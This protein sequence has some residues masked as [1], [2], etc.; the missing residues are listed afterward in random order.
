MAE[1]PEKQRP[2]KQRLAQDRE[3]LLAEATALVERIE[4]DVDEMD[5]SIVIGFRPSGAGSIYFGPDAAYHFT[6]HN[7]LRRAYA[8]GLL[9]KAEKRRLIS[10]DRRRPRRRSSTRPT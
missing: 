5:E 1:R 6:S 4:L 3:D 7:R 8:N 10:L 2:R 9:Y